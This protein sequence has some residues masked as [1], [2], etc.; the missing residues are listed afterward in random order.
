MPSPRVEQALAQFNAGKREQAR[1]SLLALVQRSPTDFAAQR[2]LAWV[3]LQL[4]QPGQAAFI[5]ERVRALAKPTRD[6]LA[7]LIEIGW[8][9]HDG[10]RRADGEACARRACTLAPSDPAALEA[11]LLMLQARFAYPEME[12]HCRAMIAATGPTPLLQTHLAN[13]L[14][15]MGES[16][17]AAALARE[18]LAADPAS[19]AAAHALAA[20][21]NYVDSATPDQILESHTHFGR[22][23]TAGIKPLAPRPPGPSD[24]DRPPRLGLVSPDFRAH[25]VASFVES[26]LPHL[27]GRLDVV[28]YYTGFTVDDSTRRIAAAA[29]LWHHVNTLGDAD[30]ASL[31]REDR[32]DV[33]IDLCGLFARGRLRVFQMRPA[34]VQATYIGYP[35]TTGL[36]AI[37]YRLVDSHTDPPGSERLA[38]ESLRRLDPCFLC[39]APPANPPPV[40]RLT[41]DDPGGVVFG[42]FNNLQKFTDSTLAMWSRVIAAVPGSRLLLKNNAF[43]DESVRARIRAALDRHG[44]R[45]ESIEILGRIDDPM[46]HLTAYRRIDIALDTFPYNGTTTTCEA[47]LMGVPVVTLAGDRHA[48]RVGVS[49]LAAVGLDSLVAATPDQ[50]VAIATALAADTDRRR[51]FRSSLR[52]TLLA[53][54]LCDAAGFA[55]RFEEA[56][57]AM[58][59]QAVAARAPA[60]APPSPQ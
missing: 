53:S 30:L 25:S 5:G 23:L 3:L 32:I 2:A 10:G 7:G 21:L 8:T 58:W 46:Q 9:F 37:D 59:R 56:V 45:L 12:A 40:E 27:K 54:P 49:L 13:A 48:A 41:T 51:A 26:F 24:A 16:E 18:V 14:L 29:G 34:P 4:G 44:L 43:T 57:T 28:C 55:R 47:L 36:T 1:A 6:D 20:T 38:T 11:L 39:Y 22:L 33:L 17:A 52:P 31:I 35:N 19:V 60:A 15:A 42:S 50:F